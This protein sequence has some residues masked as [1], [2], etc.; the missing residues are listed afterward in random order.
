[1]R[2]ESRGRIEL[3]SADPRKAPRIRQNFLATENDWKTLRAGLRMARDVCRQAP[4]RSFMAREIGPGEHAV[5]DADLDAYIRPN[6]ITV[7]HPLGTCKMGVPSDAMAVVDPQL[8]VF[9]TEGLRIVD[10]SVMPDLVGAH[11]NAPIIM[12]AEK[13]ADLIRGRPSLEAVKLAGASELS[14]H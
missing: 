11:I 14:R 9:G 1:L 2:P 7:H 6:S 4:L 10:G 3:I 5:S 8:R 12:I 13:A